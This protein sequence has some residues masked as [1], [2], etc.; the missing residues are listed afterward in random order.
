VTGVKR[1]IGAGLALGSALLSGVAGC[2]VLPGLGGGPDEGGGGSGGPAKAVNLPERT[3]YLRGDAASPAPTTGAPVRGPIASMSP[4]A[5]PSRAAASPSFS[6]PDDC[7]GVVRMGVVNGADVVPATTS[8]VVSWWNIGDPAIVEYRLAAVSQHLY[9]G[10]QP[11]WTWQTVAPGR[12]CTRV[13]A[14]VTG[15]RSGVPYVFVVHAVLEKYDTLPPTSPEV[16]R[17]SAV[18]T[19]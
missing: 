16:A 2:S 3:V 10:R 12:G 13:E 19:L 14:T 17:S 8:A 1:R 6:G 15:L 5:A 9:M 7:A 18:F 11:A 4:L